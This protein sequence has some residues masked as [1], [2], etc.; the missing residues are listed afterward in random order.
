[1]RL[2]DNLMLTYPLPPDA[3]GKDP[4]VNDTAVVRDASAGV[5]LINDGEDVEPSY[6]QAKIL[7]HL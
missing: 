3:S 4:M 2:S 1:M 7:N 5:S 6:M